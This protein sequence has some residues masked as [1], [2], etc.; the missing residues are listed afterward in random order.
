MVKKTKA[1]LFL[2]H[3]MAM[4]DAHNFFV[5]PCILNSQLASRAHL[6]IDVIDE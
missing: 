6:L 1:D 2:L 4:L 3:F 5:I